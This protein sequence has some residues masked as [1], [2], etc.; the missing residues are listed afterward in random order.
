MRI[1]I[2]MYT[3]RVEGCRKN[4]PFT[5]S[6]LLG[7]VKSN[8][9]RILATKN[10]N[11]FSCPAPIF[12]SNKV[13]GFRL[14]E[15]STKASLLAKI[16]YQVVDSGR[17]AGFASGFEPNIPRQLYL[18][19]K[20]RLKV[21]VD[22]IEQMKEEY[23]QGIIDDLSS[24]I[25]TNPHQLTLY[26]YKVTARLQYISIYDHDHTVPEIAEFLRPY[27]GRT[28]EEA[29]KELL[30]GSL[31]KLEQTSKTNL[32]AHGGRSI[33]S[34]LFKWKKEGIE[35]VEVDLPEFPDNEFQKLVQTF[36]RVS[37][38]EENKKLLGQG[39]QGHG[40]YRGVWR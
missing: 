7:A 34:I 33:C 12:T 11:C 13:A 35:E 22:E 39:Q 36:S 27:Q 2:H 19:V 18:I 16:K 9:R 40:G 31:K 3:L 8:I 38:C 1:K 37:V 26:R 28:F 4:T 30:E 20:P 29:F 10:T 6:F 32:Q 21:V 14:C 25:T 23:T 5:S 17:L 15:P 24:T